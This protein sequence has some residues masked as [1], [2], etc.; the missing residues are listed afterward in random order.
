[1]GDLT[2][3]IVSAIIA[4]ITAIYLLVALVAPERF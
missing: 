2:G 3:F 4:L 1:M